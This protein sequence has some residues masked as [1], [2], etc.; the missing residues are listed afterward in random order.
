MDSCAVTDSSHVQKDEI[1]NGN[2]I[3]ELHVRLYVYT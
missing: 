1:G 2:P 3:L